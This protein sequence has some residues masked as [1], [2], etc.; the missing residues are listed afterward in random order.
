MQYSFFILLTLDYDADGIVSASSS[1]GLGSPFEQGMKYGMEEGEADADDLMVLLQEL[2]ANRQRRVYPH[3]YSQYAKGKRYAHTQHVH[4]GMYE[5]HR[6]RKCIVISLHNA[7]AYR[8]YYI[9]YM[10]VVTQY[11][12]P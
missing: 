6:N 7:L 5:L 1:H 3:P 11:Q 4:K 9:R 2:K 10:H 8:H 12:N